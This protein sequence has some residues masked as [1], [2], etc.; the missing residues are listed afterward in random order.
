MTMSNIDEHAVCETCGGTM[1]NDG[2]RMTPYDH[3]PYSMCVKVL[4]DRA[5]AAEAKVK[6]LERIDITSIG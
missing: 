5:A 2:K 3:N 6:D 4:L 1:P